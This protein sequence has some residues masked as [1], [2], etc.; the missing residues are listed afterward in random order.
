MRVLPLLSVL[1]LVIG[2]WTVTLSSDD[3]LSKLALVTVWSAALCLSTIAFAATAVASG[4]VCWRQRH[5]EV[6]PAVLRYSVIVTVGLLIAVAYLTY[7]GM[8][9]IRTWA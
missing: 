5:S 7:W 1:S 3:P 2:L 4:V 6:R 9:G 8:I